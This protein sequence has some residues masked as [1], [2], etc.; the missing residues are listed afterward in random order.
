MLDKVAARDLVLWK[1][2]DLPDDGNLEQTLK[3][4][5]FD[6]SDNRLVRL[7]PA[8]Q[9]ISKHFGDKNLSNESIHI[10]VELGGERIVLRLDCTLLYSDNASPSPNRIKPHSLRV[11]LTSPNFQKTVSCAIVQS[12]SR[13]LI[14]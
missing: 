14:P 10:L 9:Q 8:S 2:S 7:T 1:C 3:T 5:K 13:S 6:D 4:L 11:R 12:V